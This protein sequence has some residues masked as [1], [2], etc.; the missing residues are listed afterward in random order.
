M[1]RFAIALALLGIAGFFVSTEILLRPEIFQPAEK[2]VPEEEMPTPVQE[3]ETQETEIQVDSTPR[4]DTFFSPAL[5]REA[6]VDLYQA[7]Y[8]LALFQHAPI[9]A[10]RDSFFLATF[11]FQIDGKPIGTV[12]RVIPTSE[13]SAGRLLSLVRQKLGSVIPEEKKQTLFLSD[14]LNTVMEANF[15]LNDRESFP[16]TI[17]LVAR[18]DRKVL[19][20][21]YPTE[22]HES[23]KKII[24]LFYQ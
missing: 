9:I 8:S 22:Y 15:Y 17:F 13:V 10:E 24:P 16:N 7:R 18:S 1:P 21:Q 5:L 23:V 4:A 6:G 14:A 19:A 11:S 2:P 12:S 3:L 20:F